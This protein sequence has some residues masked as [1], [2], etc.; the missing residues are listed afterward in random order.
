M[1]E[2]PSFEALRTSSKLISITNSC[3]HKIQA[4]H[5]EGNLIMNNFEINVLQF[6]LEFTP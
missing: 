5:F 3:A 2:G 1:Q 6:S 4:S